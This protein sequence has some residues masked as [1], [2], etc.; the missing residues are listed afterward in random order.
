MGS[1]TADWFP[2]PYGRFSER[3]FDGTEW[4]DRVRRADGD[5][6]ET[7]D[8]LG[9][10]IGIPFVLPIELVDDADAEL[11]DVDADSRPDDQ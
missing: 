11:D 2:D 1:V 3:F 5:G 4:T 8:P 9:T 7:I 6:D 10:S